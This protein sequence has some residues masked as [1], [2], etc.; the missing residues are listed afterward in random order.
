MRKMKSKLEVERIENLIANF[1]W[2]IV[3]QEV[4]EDEI[5]LKI[6]KTIYATAVGIDAGAS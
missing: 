4:K 2:R 3:K 1:G 6:S 5:V